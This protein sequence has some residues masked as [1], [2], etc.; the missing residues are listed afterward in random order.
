MVVVAAFWIKIAF[1]IWAF[2]AAVKI[3][4]NGYF[5]FALAAQNRIC[6]PFVLRP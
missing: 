3:F 1:A 5:A 2:V 4:I 6:A